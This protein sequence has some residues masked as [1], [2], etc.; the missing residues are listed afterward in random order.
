MIVVLLPNAGHTK[1]RLEPST[2]PQDLIGLISKTH[3]LKYDPIA[4]D[5]STFASLI[6]YGLKYRLYTVDYICCLTE[7][8]QRRLQVRHHHCKVQLHDIFVVTYCLT[9]TYVS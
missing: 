2:T 4:I 5:F 8:D 6:L 7:E 1:L 3:R 9:R